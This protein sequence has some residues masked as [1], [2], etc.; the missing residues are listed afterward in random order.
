[1]TELFYKLEYVSYLFY[2]HG[3]F[4]TYMSGATLMIKIDFYQYSG[5]KNL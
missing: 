2:G 5:K 3:R 1:L 4:T